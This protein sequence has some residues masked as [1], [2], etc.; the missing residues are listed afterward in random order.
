L[1][2]VIVTN[3]TPSATYYVKVEAAN[4]NFF[5]VGAYEV[6]TRFRFADG[7]LTAAWNSSRVFNDAHTDD[8]I[9]TATSAARTAL[10]SNDQAFDYALRAVLADS[11]DVDVYKVQS[12]AVAAGQTQALVVMVWADNPDAL[13][14]RVRVFDALGNRVAFQVIANQDGL[15]SIQI[16]NVGSNAAYYI[17]VA[18]QAPG[19]GRDIGGYTLGVNF[20]QSAPVTFTSVATGNLSSDA[21]TAAGTLSIAKD[22]L[23]TF[24]LAANTASGR[25]VAV[26]LTVTDD[27]GRVVFTLTARSGEPPRTFTAYVRPGSY[28]F[29][30][31]AVAL[32]GGALPPDVSYGL[33]AAAMSDG[34]GPLRTDTTK[35]TTSGTV[36][37]TD[38]TTTTTD[39]TTMTTSTTDYVYTSST[40]YDISLCYFGAYLFYY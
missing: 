10:A 34:I 26:T 16:P 2:T 6:G 30:Y 12:N 11:T 27:A 8:T 28:R 23:M 13:D 31:S 19:S 4:S 22:Q 32:D 35:T 33:Y 1:V 21:P 3:P 36:A 39:T 9:A 15:F 40:T 38:T 5:R 18:A 25:P 20:L 17:S 7:T 29:A 24:A 14:P 37:T